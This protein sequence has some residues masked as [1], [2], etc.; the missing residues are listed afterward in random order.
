[1]KLKDYLTE[2]IDPG[3]KKI[4]KGDQIS[5]FIGKGKNASYTLY[6]GKVKMVTK[7][8]IFVTTKMMFDHDSMRVSKHDMVL[9]ED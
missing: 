3:V 5:F 1:M 6:S 2:E 7:D 9:P 4:K 8:A